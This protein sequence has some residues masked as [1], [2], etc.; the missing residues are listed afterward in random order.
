VQLL[1]DDLANLLERKRRDGIAELLQLGDEL[2]RDEIG[3]GRS[4]LADLD[5]RRAELFQDHAHPLG[6]GVLLDVGAIAARDHLQPD[7]QI[8]ADL[9]PVNQIVEAVLDQHG[10]N[11][12]IPV[13][14]LV[15]A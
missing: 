10:E 5:E 13:H 7:F 12:P 3:A 9:Q 6:P 2:G 8:L 11:L 1:L 14:V 15:S 4:D